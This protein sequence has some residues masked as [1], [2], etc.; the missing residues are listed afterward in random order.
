M[1]NQPTTGRHRLCRRPP[2]LPTIFPSYDPPLFFVTA[3]TWKRQPIL[4][5][6]GVHQC[7]RREAARLKAFGIIVGAYVIMPDHI[8]FF[9]VV[10]S[11]LRLGSVVRQI[12]RAVTLHVRSEQNV[13]RVWQPGFFDHLMRSG[14]SY[15][16]KW[17]YVRR[18]PVRA[19]LVAEA[20]QWPFQGQICLI[21]R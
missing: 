14:E 5:T 18:N 6:E 8:H 1:T 3:C 4:A 21:R 11:G 17:E 19:G 20:S 12:K 9:V 15:S 2:R 7:F 13:V 16:E 10:P